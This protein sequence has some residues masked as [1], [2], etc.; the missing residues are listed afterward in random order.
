MTRHVVVVGA[1]PAGLAAADAALGAGARVTLVDEAEQP[2]GQ[3]HR[4]LPEAYAAARPERLH[5]GWRAFDA[6]RRRVLAHPRC[7]WWS[8][9]AVWALERPDPAEPGP[10]RVHV[11]RGP[12][13]GGGRDRPVLDPDALVLA[14]GAHDRVL[15]F[16][17][18]ELPGVFTAGAAQALAKGE[19]VVV[20]DQVVVAGS[21][22][23]L[24]PVAASLI[25]AGARVREVLEA[26][27]PATLA[28]GWGRRPW[29]LAAQAG[30][31]SELAEYSALLARHR[32]PY[33]TGRT[34]I[35]ARGDGCV[36][37]VVTARLRADWSVVQGSERTVAVDA[38]CV[39]HGFSPQLELPLA[40]GC[41]LRATP[42]GEFVEVDGDQRTTCPDVYAAGEITGVAGA[43]AARVEG[44]LAGW[45]AAGG[46]RNAVTV[47]R[48]RTSRDQGRAFAARLARAHPI[49]AG[50]SGWLRPET[51]VCRCEETDYATVCRAATDESTSAPRAAKLATRAGLGPCQARMCGPTVAEISARLRAPGDDDHTIAGLPPASEHRRP[52]ARPVRL[53]DLAATPETTATIP[54]TTA[55][56]AE[57]TDTSATNSRTEESSS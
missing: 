25:E 53:G 39:S 16:P 44:A 29:E 43:P 7:A 34:V 37:E 6:R 49:G 26:S 14:V 17:G 32:V 13:D 22:P 27:T 18:W 5:H 31:A 36:E 24:L 46:D 2:G 40:A 48:L 38:V 45:L 30:K 11:L 52:I 3:Y 20:G 33:R 15:P 47:R 57:T 19:R 51:V 4:M 41:A 23:F 42:A 35:E 9:A 8:E 10:P 1:G 55:T 21:G 50:W 12:S 54:E 56:S 28:R